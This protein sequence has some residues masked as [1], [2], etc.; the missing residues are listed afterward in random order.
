M[1]SGLVGEFPRINDAIRLEHRYG[2]FVT[3]CSLAADTMSDGLAKHDF[4]HDTTRVVEGPAAQAN[5]GEPRR[6]AVRPHP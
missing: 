1:L 4:L 2:Y 5:P 3:T 6:R